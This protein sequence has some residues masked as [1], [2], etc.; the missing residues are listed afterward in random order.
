VELVSLA[1]PAVL[2]VMKA[3]QMI[4]CL[5]MKEIIL[6]LLERPV[7]VSLVMLL[8]EIAQDRILINV[9]HVKKDIF[10]SERLVTPLAITHCTM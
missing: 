10:L 7:A 6:E 9:E 8:V 5:V 4:V 3:Q 2:H 1:I